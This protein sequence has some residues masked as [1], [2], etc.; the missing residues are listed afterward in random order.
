[1]SFPL[2]RKTV[3][4][5]RWLLIACAAT[6]FA[7]SWIR[8]IIVASMETYQLQRIARNLPDLIKRLS[9]V[10]IEQLISYP[11]LVGFTYEEPLAYLIMAVWTISRGSDIVSGEISRGTMEM[12]LAQPVS[13]L[14]YVMTHTLVTVLGVAV[15]SFA[16]YGGTYGGVTTTGI[17]NRKPARTWTV[18]LFNMKL[19]SQERKEEFEWIPMTKFVEPKVYWAASANYASLGVFLAGATTFLSSFDRYRWRTIGIIV[20]FYVIQTIVE[21]T[22]MAVEGYRWLLNFTFFA[23]YEPVATVTEASKDA[24]SAWRFWS[25]ETHG[26]I[27]D[28]GPMGCNAALLSMGAAGIIAAAIIFCRRDL[29]APL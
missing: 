16:A 14:R 19:E 18:P 23:A 7:F 26:M 17:K 21:L 4:D 3:N 12:L 10:P 5:A 29:P 15:L 25:P 27:P 6:L 24:S 28:L 2:F 1:V 22:G 8:V 9:P 11:G 13:R 20:G